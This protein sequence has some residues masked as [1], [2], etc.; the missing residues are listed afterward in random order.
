MG[1]SSWKKHVK[2]SQKHLS[3]VRGMQ[4]AAQNAESV[5]TQYKEM[6][7]MAST[8][9]R[10]PAPAPAMAPRAHFHPI[11]D[12]DTNGIGAE[13]FAMED[14]VMEEATVN[15]TELAA[16]TR[17]KNATILRR[18]IELLMLMHLEDEFEGA[19]DETIPHFTQD[20]LDNSKCMQVSFLGLSWNLN[21][22]IFQLFS[23]RTQRT[24]SMNTLQGSPQATITRHMATKLYAV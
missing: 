2:D 23:N 10:T 15:F 13:D 19:E 22:E 8:S 18:E 5:N 14:F 21:A 9:L 4:E 20:I 16:E 17:A 11:L 7:S 6:Y 12:E 3:I 24:T 1:R